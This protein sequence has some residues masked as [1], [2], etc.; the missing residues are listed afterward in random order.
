MKYK[1]IWLGLICGGAV[2]LIATFSFALYTFYPTVVSF[3]PAFFCCVLAVF[4]LKTDTWKAFFMSILF[5]VIGFFAVEIMIV[6]AVI[7]LF[8]YRIKYSNAID[9]PV[10]GGIIIVINYIIHAIS[11]IIG[12]FIAGILMVLKRGKASAVQA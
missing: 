1:H 7:P 9:I 5:V 11:L 2:S 10:G 8:L 6:S 12:I 4:L 3:L